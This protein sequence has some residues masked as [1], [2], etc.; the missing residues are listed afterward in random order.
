MKAYVR[1]VIKTSPVDGPGNRF[2]IFFQGCNLNCLYC[3][4]PETI[5]FKKD[6]ISEFHKDL[7][8]L[9][10]DVV[11]IKGFINGV[12]IS[13]GECTVQI[14]ELIYLAKGLKANGIHVLIDSN[15]LVDSQKLEDLSQAV[16]GFMFDLKTLDLQDHISLT[17]KPN[18]DILE[19]IH[20]MAL[21][22]KLYE[23]RL[24]IVPNLINNE[25]N[26]AYASKLI[27]NSGNYTRLKLIKLRNHGSRKDLI[28]QPSPSDDY[29]ANLKNIAQTAGVKEIILV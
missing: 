5:T 29:M 21:T 17:G 20:R 9:I 2:V 3:H 16:D 7:D 8:V 24:V 6:E 13:G 26:V 1:S 11:K 22:K 27:I 15:A 19:N 18:Q 28:D 4:N 12:T 10:E 23:L 25:A 14:K